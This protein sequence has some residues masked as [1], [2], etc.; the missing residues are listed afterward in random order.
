M[1]YHLFLAY[2]RGQG[3]PTKEL[4]EKMFKILFGLLEVC[5]VSLFSSLKN[6]KKQSLEFKLIFVL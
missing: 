6:Q 5:L 2:V 4:Y 3:S 1:K